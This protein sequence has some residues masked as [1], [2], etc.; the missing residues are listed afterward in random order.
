MAVSQGIK[1]QTETREEAE[2][3]Q[4]DVV[5]KA[6]VVR[7]ALGV[8]SSHIL[9]AGRPENHDHVILSTSTRRRSHELC[10]RW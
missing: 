10:E 8:S 5:V 4:G 1:Q 2:E 3:A 7:R 6:L 9:R